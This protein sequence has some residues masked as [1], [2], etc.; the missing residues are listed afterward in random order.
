MATRILSESTWRR[1]WRDLEQFRASFIG[2]WSIEVLAA[3]AGGIVAVWWLASTTSS[4]AAQAFYGAIGVGVGLGVAFVGIYVFNLVLAP[5]RQR[6]DVREEV[7][8]LQAQMDELK[9]QPKL[10]IVFESGQTFKQIQRVRDQ[11]RGTYTETLY[12]VGV[13]HTAIATID[14]VEVELESIEPLV[15][16]GIPLS[17]HIMNDNPLPGTPYR[18]AFPLDAGYRQFIDVAFKR[19]FDGQPPSDEIFI[20]HAVLGVSQRIPAQRYEIA[21]LT[22]GHNVASARQNF[23]IDVDDTGALQFQHEVSSS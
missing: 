18:R 6:N 11:R 2:F 17:L 15:L 10:E 4:P 21:I 13:E 5:Y 16:L 9:A 23:I 14:R 7:G 12:R 19:D 8:S 1:A 3:L 20:F 22:R